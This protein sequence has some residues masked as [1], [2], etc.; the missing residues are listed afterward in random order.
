[1]DPFYTEQSSGPTRPRLGEN[2]ENREMSKSRSFAGLRRSAGLLNLKLSSPTP[3]DAH[4]DESPSTP[5]PTNFDDTPLSIPH[6][7]ILKTR[8]SN[9]QLNQQ[10]KHQN[11]VSGQLKQHQQQPQFDH[12][13]DA[14]L[15]YTPLGMGALTPDQSM[16]TPSARAKRNVSLKR[17]H[18]FSSSKPNKSGFLSRSTAT[19]N[20]PS[21]APSK[22]LHAD[23]SFQGARP[24][25]TAF[26]PHGLLSKRNAVQS[27][28]PRV[29]DTPCKRALPQPSASSASRHF[30]ENIDG[31]SRNSFSRNSDDFSRNDTSG[32]EARFA[33]RA[34]QNSL[35]E[36]ATIDRLQRFSIHD[37]DETIPP[38]TPTRFGVHTSTPLARNSSRGSRGGLSTSGPQK[39]LSGVL[40][41]VDP[42]DSLSLCPPDS[43]ESALLINSSSLSDAS[44]GS[45]QTPDQLDERSMARMEA[46]TT[47]SSPRPKHLR[48]FDLRKSGSGNSMDDEAQAPLVP[49]V[50][51]T[52]MED[53]MPILRV[54]TPTTPATTSFSA[55]SLPFAPNHPEN[56]G[57]IPRDDSSYSSGSMLFDE[58]LA[59]KFE[60]VQTSQLGEFSA[61]FVVVQGKQRLAVKRT[62]RPLMSLRERLRFKEEVSI[63]QS[64][65]EVAEAEQ[66]DLE[67]SGTGA[68]D[69]SGVV[70]H[71][72]SSHIVQLMDTWEHDSFGYIMTEYC[73][74]GDL[75]RFLAAQGRVSR[76]EEW[77]VWKILVEVLQGLAVVHEHGILHL[78][79]KPANVFVTFEGHLKIGD[80]GMATRYPVPPHFEREGDREYIAP[81]VLERQE[82]ST[83]ADIFSLG[84]MMVEVAA[85]IV[86]P[87]NG[88]HWQRLRS[89]DLSDAGRLSSGDLNS[90]LAHASSLSGHKTRAPP[91]W[92]PRFLIDGSYVLD[93]LVS[94]MLNPHP[95]KRPS[96]T[97]LLK[98]SEIELVNI[99]GQA[100]AVVYE[101]EYGPEPEE[102]GEVWQ[103]A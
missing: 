14:P 22:R 54:S 13:R 65:S 93:H 8:P 34:R 9:Q 77:R 67:A 72:R 38:E 73:E 97:D 43:I 79:L 92:A 1:M 87:D 85:N 49:P 82:Y 3:Q 61:V 81:E 35:D 45:P 100:G 74:N 89:G 41:S 91:P 83:A 95:E 44:M 52:R 60:K 4:F 6:K 21:A 96:A 71:T 42:A 69:D 53:D 101:G 18:P 102:E 27:P 15:G 50:I 78:D 90:T 75:N 99:R 80:F 29:P 70:V 55:A 24:V 51:N 56:P 26:A 84:I 19:V 66:A 32:L 58:S 36:N 46:G 98:R 12:S 86:L 7:P 10:L 59:Q 64:L 94:A 25:Q 103:R 76:L 68:E 63:L 39:S 48:L 17:P 5:T 37:M 30:D 16:Q 11:R 2:G 28:A 40:Q 31:F 33:G 20:T 57:F 88:V 62:K 23:V 47:A